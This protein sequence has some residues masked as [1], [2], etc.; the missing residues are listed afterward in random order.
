MDPEKDEI[1][2]EA[3]VAIDPRLQ[4]LA[5]LGITYEEFEES[6]SV[7]IEAREALAQRDDVAEEEIPFFEEML[8]N[9][10]GRV[11]RLEDLADVEIRDN[12]D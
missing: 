12:L 6:L 4:V 3:E 2:G 8:L 5:D 7:A 1:I 11:Y 10:R 9:I